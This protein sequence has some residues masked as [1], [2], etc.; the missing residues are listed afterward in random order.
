MKKVNNISVLLLVVLIF[1]G[2]SCE[3]IDE[4]EA[5][6]P[7]DVFIGT[8]SVN[9]TCSKSNYTVSISN[10]PYNSSQVLLSNFA[11]PNMGDPAVGIVTTNKITLDPSQKIGNNW[12]VSG[13]GNYI[14]HTLIEWTFSIEIAGNQENCSADYTR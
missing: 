14:S 10:D 11:N 8:W 6:D 3:P 2:I 1:S 9:E 4:P 12:T 7:R 5:D 13:T